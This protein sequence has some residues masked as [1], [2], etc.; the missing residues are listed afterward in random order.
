M[1]DE[2]L[3]DDPDALARADTRGLL[4]GVAAAGARVRTAARL[5][6]EAGIGELTPDGRPRSVLVAGP[7]AVAVA[8]VAELLAAL[9]NGSGP[10]LSLHPTGPAPYDLR[11][12]LPGWAGPLDLL[13]IASPTGTEAGLADLIEQAYRRG[14]T[15]AAVVPAGSPIAEAIQQVRGMVL[16]YAPA[17]DP[18]SVAGVLG[19]A[20]DPT[21]DLGAFWA[22]LTPLL[23]LGDRIGLLA[24]PPDAIERVADRLDD[25]AGRCGPA[26]ATYG[27]PAKAL[28]SEL[29]ES[30]PVMWSDGP[31]ASVAA[32]RFA[33]A[34]AARAGRP[35]LHGEL[36]EALDT[37]G[38]L[39]AGALAGALDPDDFFRDRVDEPE[40]LRLRVVLLH[41][42]GNGAASSAPLARELATTHDTPMSELAPA[43][44]GDL[45]SAVEL[46]AV[47]DFA[48]V[49]L[50]IT[51]TGR[52]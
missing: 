10:V 35:A 16:P 24:A 6:Q 23:A 2:T 9:G 27:N 34:I 28:A 32:R 25:V 7:G 8:A 18:A 48:S 5:A 37:H 33:A 14:C 20:A 19:E 38:A 44:G 39:L 43:E 36:P 30:L 12:T 47:T 13:L 3:L 4:L 17:P 11:W 45:E 1:L 22:L 15:A 29:A 21:E 50:A 31:V 41:R 26:T 40:D 42:P 51:S 52:A 46:L 49:Y